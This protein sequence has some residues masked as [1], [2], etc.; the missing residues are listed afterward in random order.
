MT[1]PTITANQ[2]SPWL[3]VALGMV[4]VVAFALWWWSGE[5]VAPPNPNAADSLGEDYAAGL[6]ATSSTD[7]VPQE[8]SREIVGE[9]IEGMWSLIVTVVD[10]N[11]DPVA[12]AA[13]ELQATAK[14]A[15]SD[16]GRTNADGVCRLEVT[17]DRVF[18]RAYHSRIGRS[19]LV[20]VTEEGYVDQQLRLLL[21]RSV[22]VTGIVLGAD[23]R[24]WPGVRVSLEARHLLY[25][26]NSPHVWPT[27]VVTNAAGRF[28]FEAGAEVP[29]L[30]RLL[31]PGLGNIK[32]HWIATKG[33]QV[34]LAAPGALRIEGVVVDHAGN[35][36][37]ARVL[38]SSAEDFR[39]RA[40]DIRPAERFS[41]QPKTLGKHMV[42]ATAEGNLVAKAIVELRADKPRAY[43][44]L[45]LKE[46]KAPAESE[47][48]SPPSFQPVDASKSGFHPTVVVPPANGLAITLDVIGADGEPA[49]DL[50]VSRASELGSVQNV[51]LGLG[52]G[53]KATLRVSQVADRP[54]RVLIS[55]N[56]GAEYG[57]FDLGEGPVPPRVTVRLGKRGSVSIEARCRG[58]VA[59]GVRLQMWT[60]HEPFWSGN[61]KHLLRADD[62]PSGPALIVVRRGFEIVGTKTIIVQPGVLTTDTVEV[63]LR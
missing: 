42:T 61:D 51:S 18:V 8:T 7:L 19:L 16:A 29:G 32:A 53:G 58:R 47:Q 2:G 46:R 59:R 48:P 27:Q 33:A 9:M 36:R 50:E 49:N 52:G 54:M 62:V 40:E 39:V 20:A 41:V 21:W 57:W 4:A 10:A 11:G 55:S 35:P 44:E 60:H 25:G 24:P 34:V 45:Q 63:K 12:A 38:L 56:D 43:V 37:P 26:S 14:G 6:A 31:G 22:R 15:A 23:S 1:E 13:I 5:D 30:A 17:S 28:E 3:R